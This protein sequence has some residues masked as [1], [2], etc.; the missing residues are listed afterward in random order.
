MM[1]EEISRIL[2]E[3]EERA[4]ELLLK[5]RGG[6]DLVAE[7]LLEKET[8]DG[9][10]VARSSRPASPTRRR[11]RPPTHVDATTVT[12]SSTSRLTRTV[13]V[14]RSPWSGLADRRRGSGSSPAAGLGDGGPQVGGGDG[15]EE[16]RRAR[17]PPSASTAS[18]RRRSRSGAARGCALYSIS[19]TATVGAGQHLCLAHH[20]GA[21][22]ARRRAR[23]RRRSHARRRRE[24]GSVELRRRRDTGCVG[25]STAAPAPQDQ[26]RRPRRRRARA[27]AMSSWCH[28]VSRQSERAERPRRSA[29]A[30]GA[31]RRRTAAR[32][33]RRTG[34]RAPSGP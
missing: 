18:G 23:T 21:R 11:R 34:C 7:A 33:R 8:I 6:L 1:D 22:R 16:A 30:G 13:P 29:R 2:L 28:V 10:E 27:A 20:V 24:V 9:S 14:S 32:S 26:R 3:Q 25:A 4:H 5:H 17:R 19:A 12:R 31:A 15:A